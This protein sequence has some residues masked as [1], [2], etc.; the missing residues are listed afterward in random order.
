MLKKQIVRIKWDGQS[1]KQRNQ[2]TG[3]QTI[4]PGSMA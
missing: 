3:T 2:Q 4:D 1:A